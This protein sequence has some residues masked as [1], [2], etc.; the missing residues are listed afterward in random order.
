MNTAIKDVKFGDPELMHGPIEE[1]PRVTGNASCNHW[2]CDGLCMVIEDVPGDETIAKQDADEPRKPKFDYKAIN[3]YRQEQYAKG[4]CEIGVYVLGLHCTQ[5][6]KH[7]WGHGSIIHVCD[8]HSTWNPFM[9][10][11]GKCPD[12]GDLAD[13]YPCKA[14]ENVELQDEDVEGDDIIAKQ[15][16][17]EIATN[18]RTGKEDV[19]PS[20]GA[21][22]YETAVGSPSSLQTRTNTDIVARIFGLCHVGCDYHW[23]RFAHCRL[24]RFSQSGP[25][26]GKEPTRNRQERGKD[27]RLRD[28]EPL[29]RPCVCSGANGGR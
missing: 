9:L 14:E 8:I 5:P 18:R 23:N 10:E 12:C 6:A 28:V 2:D 27:Q 16:A 21:T 29:T 13:H 7:G 24:F 19:C 20:C 1:G 17:E 3:K 11:G 15:D 26:T 22:L 25:P 4:Q